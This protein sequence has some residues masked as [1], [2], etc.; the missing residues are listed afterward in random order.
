MGFV[1][2]QSTSRNRLFVIESQ[3]VISP[4]VAMALA[5]TL[6]AAVKIQQNIAN[7]KSLKDF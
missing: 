5:L 7:T 1:N 3:K 2:S 4:A 6:I